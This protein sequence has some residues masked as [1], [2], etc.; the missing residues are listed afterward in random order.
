MSCPK[1]HHILNCLILKGILLEDFS[2]VWTSED[3][4]PTSKSDGLDQSGRD[5]IDR[6]MLSR[7]TKE[8]RE[9]AY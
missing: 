9:M 8:S 3:I 1:E 6:K 2:L 5:T 4:C 7:I